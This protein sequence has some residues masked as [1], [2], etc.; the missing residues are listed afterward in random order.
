MKYILCL[1]GY[2]VL[3][4]STV[5]A[6]GQQLQL[7][8]CGTDEV[9]QKYLEENPEAKEQMAKSLKGF[10]K[11][12]S[13]F[14][15]QKKDPNSAY[16]KNGTGEYIIPVV[17][18]NIYGDENGPEYITQK[19][20]KDAI[21]R[22]NQDFSGVTANVDGGNADLEPNPD[23]PAIEL[24][25]SSVYNYCTAPLSTET[26]TNDPAITPAKITFRL[27]EKDKYGNP[28]S[29][30]TRTKDVISY[31][32]KGDG[33]E[34]R[35]II[36][37]DRNKYLNIYI[38][39][40][41]NGASS[42]V[43]QYPYYTDNKPGTDG[44]AMPYWSFVC[45][46]DFSTNA[47]FASTITH[48]V[49]HW[50]GLRHIWGEDGAADRCQ[51]DDFD[52]LY[53][54]LNYYLPNENTG[55]QTEI[56]FI[57]ANFN[58]TPNCQEHGMHSGVCEV[59]PESSC[60]SEDY[61][62][63]NFMDY[64][65]C[66]RTFSPGQ[67]NYMECVLNSPL[68]QR[69]EIQGNLPN[70][71]YYDVATETDL[72]TPH[73]VFMS[74][75]FEEDACN[76]GSIKNELPIKLEHTTF[77]STLGTGILSS[78]YYTMTPPVGMSIANL[79][80]EVEI[81]DE[82]SAVLRLNAQWLTN[83]IEDIEGI[84]FVFQNASNSLF[85]NTVAISDRS[86][87]ININSQEIVEVGLQDIC[88]NY[89]LGP[90]GLGLGV[91]KINELFF[92]TYYKEESFYLASDNLLLQFCSYTDSNNQEW[93][94]LFG[95]SEYIN[96]NSGEFSFSA[97]SVDFP[98]KGLLNLSDLQNLSSGDFF[99]IGLKYGLEDCISQY[100][101]L[102]L[103]LD[104]CDGQ[105]NI[106]VH[107]FKLENTPTV[108]SITGN[109]GEPIIDFSTNIFEEGFED[110]GSFPETIKIRL[111]ESGN[112]T[113]AS[114]LSVN[115][116]TISG[117]NTNNLVFEMN[118]IP[119]TNNLEAE[120]AIV[121]NF[122]PLE[123]EEEV[124]FI[125]FSPSAFNGY[126]P[127]FKM[128]C[129]GK[130]KLDYYQPNNGTISFSQNGG[131]DAREFYT[132]LN[133]GQNSVLSSNWQTN[134]KLDFLIHPLGNVAD[135]VSCDTSV[136]PAVLVGVP[137]AGYIIYKTSPSFFQIE[138]Y[139][140]PGSREAMLFTANTLPSGGVYQASLFGGFDDQCGSKI[141]SFDDIYFKT[142]DLDAITEDYAYL[143]FKIPKDCGEEYYAWVEI[144]LT[145]PEPTFDIFHYSHQANSPIVMGEYSGAACL[146]EVTYPDNYHA[147]YISDVVLNG[148]DGTG[149]NNVSS[150]NSG[151]NSEN[152]ETA[153]ADYTNFSVNL[154]AGETYPITLDAL[155]SHNLPNGEEPLPQYENWGVWI[156]W[157][158]NPFTFGYLEQVL[159]EES[160]NYFIEIPE[161]I[162]EG[163]YTMRIIVSYY[164]IGDVCGNIIYGEV[165]DYT[166]VIGS[167]G[168]PPPPP[169]PNEECCPANKT[170]N[171][172]S[173]LPAVTA[174]QNS[175]ITSYTSVDVSESVVFQAG[176]YIQLY[177]NFTAHQG[178]TFLASIQECDVN[179]CNNGNRLGEE[180]IVQNIN[181]R[182]F[183]LY[184]NPTEHHFTFECVLQEETKISLELYN[185]T[186]KLEKPII[187]QEAQPAG[188]YQLE[189][190]MSDLPRGVYILKA[191]I[192]YEQY[193]KK[194]I[195]M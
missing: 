172:T 183:K 111:N 52:H 8:G 123:I 10:L 47:R 82:D 44:V 192:G 9:Y 186:G 6:N 36:Q 134:G 16:N 75:T 112:V 69:N 175:I 88:P 32:S 163:S 179:L 4:F 128:S 12:A 95:E 119:N 147:T 144:D 151:E 92:Y 39:N 102:R 156:N 146:P 45:A 171:F 51:V 48:E 157:D 17:F 107:D 131:F 164:P 62:Y 158:D 53:N 160:G 135:G 30:I 42:G 77:N 65:P 86:K 103:Q 190:D 165:E 79:V 84:D 159:V 143:A 71:L 43:A 11:E 168:T 3:L 57:N 178:G 49:G 20:A 161:G 125:D 153:Y 24:E 121:N 14:M 72:A 80:P 110:N 118:V 63:D 64:T 188:L 34:L 109:F 142:S 182:Q 15:E 127:N 115:D 173:P 152:S 85:T 104:D 60:D 40:A 19:H 176:D 66:M 180:G 137:E 138:T 139:C 7:G 23:C 58:D 87:K 70:T 150:G 124:I 100:G 91:F 132:Q 98:E 97:P 27:A 37:W 2:M 116:L 90:N 101:W 38:V 59:R 167:G 68:S 126:L 26:G 67:V 83:N 155:V 133:W 89:Y 5:A 13:K 122:N 174:V 78:D 189:V 81:I 54:S 1:C 25:T 18:H 21:R 31:A 170:Y 193:N 187:A 74:A 76:I 33:P 194:I 56:D 162:S 29:G 191:Q 141:K 169:P 61:F 73:V 148:V 181:D 117:P 129:D 140:F 55:T 106:I 93:V 22:L 195:K 96:S 184:P 149:I 41:S 50:L 113:F 177:P 130:I 35:D 145:G 105:T 114:S 108:S 120:L 46:K 136:D 28:T 185:G 166:V 154:N 99:Y 94:K